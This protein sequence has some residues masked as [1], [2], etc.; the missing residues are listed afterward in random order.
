[1]ETVVCRLNPRK[2][3]TENLTY[4]TRLAYTT[5]SKVLVYRNREKPS[6]KQPYN[7]QSIKNKDASIDRN[8]KLYSVQA[9]H[10]LFCSQKF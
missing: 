7:V 4:I 8:G 3:L 6:W 10:L 9:K 2:S 5:G 1:M